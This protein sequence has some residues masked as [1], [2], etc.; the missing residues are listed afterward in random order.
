MSHVEQIAELVKVWEDN[1]ERLDWD[2]YFMSTSL[3]ISSRSSCERLRVG[4]VLVKNNRIISSG[5]N[6]FLPKAPH[7]SVVRNDHEQGTVHAEQNCV[8]DCARRGVST[9]GATA[10]VTHYPCINCAKILSSAGIKMVKY[11]SDYKNDE[12]VSLILA[13]SGVIIMKL[14]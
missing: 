9:E 2:Q 7:K 10:Y 5:Y 12:L 13:M 14:D 8:S 3:L 1:G 11:R 6:G 4:C